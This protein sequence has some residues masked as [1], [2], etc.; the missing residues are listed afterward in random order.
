MF[1]DHFDYGSVRLSIVGGSEIIT[2]NS[3]NH[4][5][6]EVRRGFGLRFGE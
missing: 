6:S 2:R 5:G 3:I 1:F 4:V